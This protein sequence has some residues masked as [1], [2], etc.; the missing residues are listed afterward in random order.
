MNGQLK[1]FSVIVVT[2][3]SG[4]RLITTVNSVLSQT[5]DD[6][7][8]L[9][10]DGGSTD[11]SVERVAE[12]NNSTI[13]IVKS[14]DK[15]IYDAMNQAVSNTE[16]KFLIF[17][18]AGDYFYSNDVLKEVAERQLPCKKTIAYGD[19]YFRSSDSLSQA[20]PRITASVCYRNIPCHQAIFY[21]RDTL[22]DRPFD[23]S[24]KIRADFE[25]FLF[26]FFT[27]KCNFVY[28]HMAVCDYEGGGFSESKV[29]KRIDSAEYR[30]AVRTHIPLKNRFV[31][32]AYLIL[33]LHKLRGV[34]AKSPAFASKYQKLKTF[35]YKHKG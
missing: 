16:G 14:E 11:G 25:H 31:Y 35:L 30:R 1:E 10:K 24:Y 8:I 23:I 4:D 3:N 18:N 20:P 17:L 33:T 2:L 32:R 9:I 19:T 13:R 26:S 34:I 21:S 6:Y 27:G 5:Y 7:E 28:L 22:I 15:G 29:N 12:L